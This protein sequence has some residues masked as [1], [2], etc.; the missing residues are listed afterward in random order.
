M[1]LSSG[2]PSAMGLYLIVYPS[3]CPNTDTV[4]YGA[5]T[6]VAANEDPALAEKMIASVEEI[7]VTR[8][9]PSKI[10]KVFL[11]RLI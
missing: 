5:V 11:V 2:T 7:L 10:A 8:S 9:H 3:S 1:A 4:A 6:T